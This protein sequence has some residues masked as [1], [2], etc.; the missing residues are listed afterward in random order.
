LRVAEAANGDTISDSW[1]DRLFDAL[2]VAPVWIGVGIAIA[3][4]ASFVLLSAAFGGLSEFLAGDE[5]FWEERD[6]RL[7]VV[8]LILAAFVPTAERYARI[9]ARRNFQ[10]LLPLL[11]A[12]ESPP[13]AARF[14]PVDGR[15]RRAAGWLGLLLAPIAGLAIDRD[16]GL[17]LR[18]GYWHAENAWA[19]FVGALFCFGLGRFVDTTLGISRRFSELA[20]GLPRIDLLDLAP[21]APFGRQGLLFALLWLLMPSIFALN[22]MDRSFALPIALLALICVAIATAAL[23]LPVFGVHRRI[24]EA[25]AAELA[26]VVAAIRGEPA[27]LAGS[28][29]ARREAS[30]GLAD[31]IAW[32]GL[33]DS[34]R[35]WPFDASMRLRFLLYLAIPVGSWLGGALV[36]RLLGAAL[37]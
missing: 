30:A 26:R 37:G 5:S 8:L 13:L 22:A 31:L 2:P 17:Y 34:A 35:E 23:L 20:Q 14:A 32:R 12:S 11:G 18:A 36:E 27:A 9:G 15:R 28:A 16:P 19:W 29:I 1:S 33:V 6:A 21:L 3:L 7:G 24:R 25:K 10:A 4:L